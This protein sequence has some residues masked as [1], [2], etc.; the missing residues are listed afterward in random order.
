MVVALIL[1]ASISGLGMIITSNMLIIQEKLVGG[2]TI[3]NGMSKVLC[4][5][6]MAIQITTIGVLVTGIMHATALKLP[7]AYLDLQTS[8]HRWELL[9]ARAFLKVTINNIYGVLIPVQSTFMKAMAL[10]ISV[11]TIYVST[12]QMYIMWIE[13]CM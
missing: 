13:R 2:R 7:L 10:L 3:I 6:S 1:A 8:V 9:A 12:L 5:L 11:E 4:L